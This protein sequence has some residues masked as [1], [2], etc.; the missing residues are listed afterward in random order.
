M[1]V[2]WSLGPGLFVLPG[3]SELE[4]HTIVWRGADH[5]QS[6]SH[7]RGKGEVFCLKHSKQAWCQTLG[8]LTSHSLTVSTTVPDIRRTELGTHIFCRQV[9]QWSVMDWS[10]LAAFSDMSVMG[11]NGWVLL[12]CQCQFVDRR[13]I[14][15]W[16]GSLAHTAV[17]RFT[18]CQGKA[19]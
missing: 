13:V 5:S 6:L 18:S 19:G 14:S 1:A 10:I 2:S 16:V 15:L 12:G 17:K 3:F 8:K 9:F 11:S 7:Y 4:N